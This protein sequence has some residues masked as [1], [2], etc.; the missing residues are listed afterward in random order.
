MPVIQFGPK[1][2]LQTKVVEA[3]T[4]P[5][6]ITKVEG[7]KASSSG[8]SVSYYV[9]FMIC[10]GGPYSGKTRTVA[11]NSGVNSPMLG[12]MVMYPMA[13]LLTVAKAAGLDDGQPKQ[14]NFDTD[15][16]L[17]AKLD[18]AWATATEEGRLINTIT[19]F[20]PAGY[21]ASVPAF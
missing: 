4:Y 11:F 6:E 10:D 12:D 18:V 1:D 7:P 13:E 15:T 14:I 20:F 16:L 5:C 2:Y 17:H 8:K 19:G 21:A 9:D 3:K